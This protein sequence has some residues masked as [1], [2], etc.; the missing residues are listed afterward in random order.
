MKHFINA[1]NNIVTESLD[2]FLAT[3]TT[4]GLA[5]LDGYPH[6]KVIVRTDWDK[7]RVALICGGGSGHEP[8]HAAFVGAGM[9]TAAVCGEIFASPSVDAVLSAI[10]AVT[11]AAGCLL[12]V[13][14][15]TGDRLNFGLAAERAKLLGF[16]VEMVIVADDIAIPD[17]DQ[18]RGVAG[19]LFIHKIAGYLSEKGKNLA[20]IKKAAKA[21]ISECYSIGLSLD[22]CTVPGNVKDDYLGLDEAELGLGIHGE[23][24]FS[25]IALADADKLMDTACQKLAAT[26]PDK[27]F[28][29]ILNNLGAVPP[30][31]MTILANAYLK[32]ELAEKTGLLIGPAH[33]MTSLN[34]NGFSI[35]LLV[36]DEMRKVALMSDV[37]A[38]GWPG[39]RVPADIKILELPEAGQ[40]E[41]YEP[42]RNRVVET[43][44]YAVC[45]MLIKA[46]N[47]LNFL[48]SRIGDGDTGSTFSGGARSVGEAM[49]SLPCDDGSELCMALS[50]ILSRNMGG[51]SGVLLAILFMAAGKSYSDKPDWASALLQGAEQ[52][53]HYGGAQVGDRTM[54]DALMPGLNVLM[55]GRSMAEAAL[56]ARAGANATAQ[57]S[58]ARAGRA[59]Y[60]HTDNLLGVIDPGAEAM[61]R[62][63]ETIAAII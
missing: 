35:S 24:G 45:T 26:V 18:P 59:S 63:F 33:L 61:A 49:D 21:A 54:L 5:R 2:G 9:L 13:K 29:V 37:G 55:R 40:K 58:N 11:G 16:R 8:A 22:S 32:T 48:D 62:I 15:Y 38:S 25:K 46:E 52:M 36:L 4:R 7:S 51:S 12:I 19:T 28:A 44:L 20:V 1:K 50:G 6:T 53:M 31:E 57:M 43:V 42:S 34:M 27:S 10:M 47:D 39:T 30:L 14:N 41:N 3:T 23:P 56:T 17:A 60:V